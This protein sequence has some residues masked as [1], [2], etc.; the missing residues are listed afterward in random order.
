[1]KQPLDYEGWIA[2]NEYG[3]KVALTEKKEFDVPVFLGRMTL[4][5]NSSVSLKDFNFKFH[6]KIVQLFCMRTHRLKITRG[7]SERPSREPKK[8]SYITEP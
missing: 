8:N 3:L 2:E 7:V 5:E 4:E 6:F 1:M